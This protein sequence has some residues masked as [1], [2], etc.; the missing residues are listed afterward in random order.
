MEA[1][2][3]RERVFRHDQYKW[4]VFY[5]RWRNN[6][7]EEITGNRELEV[8]KMLSVWGIPIIPTARRM[9]YILSQ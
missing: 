8:T 9:N 6:L 5:Y 3:V 1:L 7:S 4:E 2:G